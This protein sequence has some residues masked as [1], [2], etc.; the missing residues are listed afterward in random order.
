L[1]R[2]PIGQCRHLL[3][4]VVE[5]AVRDITSN[6]AEREELTRLAQALIC[7]HRPNGARVDTPHVAVVALP[8]VFGPYP[9]GRVRRLALVGHGCEHGLAREIFEA[10]VAYASG[11]QLVDGGR[12]TGVTLRRESD[13]DWLHLL[14]AA[15]KEWESVTPVVLDRP[16]FVRKQWVQLGYRARHSEA[17]GGDS[18]AALMIDK[19]LANRRSEL[20][21]E[22]V[23]RIGIGGP[24]AE[25]LARAPWRAGLHHA[26][27]YRTTGYL[28]ASP[29]FHVRLTFATPV[30]G[31]LLLG[32]GRFVGFGLFR[33]RP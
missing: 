9:D 11:R 17:K 27:A 29:R 33:P 21:H 14:T 16:E 31:P 8:S 26:N 24:V 25:E 10:V 1:L 32:R 28:Q 20:L 18:K 30:Y 13:A 5:D 23:N 12:T 4:G 7:G 3:S 2:I 19:A 6:F 22:A 15:A